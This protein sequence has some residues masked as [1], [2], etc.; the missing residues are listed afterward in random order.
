MIPTWVVFAELF[1]FVALLTYITIK[2]CLY[3]VEE[4]REKQ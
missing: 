1:G 3:R 2:L 4:E